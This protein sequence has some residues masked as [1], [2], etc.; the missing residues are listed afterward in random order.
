MKNETRTHEP[1][2]AQLRQWRERR[3][4]SQLQLALEVEMSTRHLSFVE[5]GRA[6]PSRDLIIRLADY[7][8]IPLRA[9]GFD[10]AQMPG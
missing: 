1:A 6:Q 3:R 2:G 5:T 9:P 10:E 4:L 7:L 8:D